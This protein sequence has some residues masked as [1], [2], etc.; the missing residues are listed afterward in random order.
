MWRFQILEATASASPRRI[1]NLP[2]IPQRVL[3][4]EE[5]FI[6]PILLCLGS[7]TPGN[8]WPSVGFPH[9]PIPLA[10]NF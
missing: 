8:P 4:K 5:A 7:S 6:S 3:G 9:D 1:G 2:K 10:L